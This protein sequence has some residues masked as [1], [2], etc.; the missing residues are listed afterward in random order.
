M[1]PC[2][3]GLGVVVASLAGALWLAPGVQA[4][5]LRASA[6]LT[7]GS[8]GGPASADPAAPA[9]GD[10]AAGAELEREV[11]AG[12]HWRLSTPHGPV[13]VWT[14]KGYNSATAA[15]VVYVHGFYTNVDRA[16]TEHQ[17]PEQFALSGINAMFIACESPSG[18]R[19]AVSWRSLASLLQT[20]RAGI[21]RRLPQGRLVVVGHS[22]A[23][24]TITQWLDNR[25]IDTVVLMDAAYGEIEL[26]R[27][28]ING[29]RKRR[30]IDVGDDTMRWTDAL[31]RSL[32]STVVVDR[33]PPARAGFLPL[34]AQDARIVYIRS[35]LGHM[36]LVTGG[37]A[38]PMVLRALSVE[39]LPE[40]LLD[41]PL[42]VLPPLPGDDGAGD[43]ATVAGAKAAPGR[44]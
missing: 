37:V 44:S 38:L 13:H 31:H 8:G 14:P 16:W 29:S 5:P 3:S 24:R 39:I 6:S 19:D 36:P 10:A 30:L 11:A 32:P 7:A 34:E 1:R 18:T 2:V 9:T 27:D 43:D 28:W 42:G 40:Q 23:H 21:G 4:A 35:Q 26:Y 15:I 12:T 41:E 33:F 17:L 20:V 25:G 22:G